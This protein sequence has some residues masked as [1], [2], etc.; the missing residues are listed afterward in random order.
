VPAGRVFVRELRH[1]PERIWSA[2]TERRELREWAPFDPDRD[3]DTVGAATLTTAGGDGSD[4]SR[5]S[6]L[7]RQSLTAGR[8][9]RT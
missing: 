6:V 9:R 4:K 2:L 1:S 5:S 8:T 7:R 3:L